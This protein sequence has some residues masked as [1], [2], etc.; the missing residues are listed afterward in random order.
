[1]IY[2]DK[3]GRYAAEAT[4]KPVRTVAGIK[5]ATD[6]NHICTCL[7]IASLLL[8]IPAPFAVWA[9]W[10]SFDAHD[11]ADIPAGLGTWAAFICGL[12][13]CALFIVGCGIAALN[14]H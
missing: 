7:A 2:R 4:G 13:I 8:A 1:M 10:K 5:S 12:A 9:A 11:D 14:H 6:L 3:R